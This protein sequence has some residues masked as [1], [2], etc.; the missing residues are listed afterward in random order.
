MNRL[1]VALLSVLIVVVVAHGF[2][3]WRAGEQA[4]EQAERQT[5]LQDTQATA[6]LGL[7]LPTMITPA[8]DIDREGQLE[9]LAAI[10]AQLDEC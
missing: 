4:Q 9:S 8:E 7:M 1:I 6:I 2:V 10:S 5:C 3:V